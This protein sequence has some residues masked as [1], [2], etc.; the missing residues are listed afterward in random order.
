MNYQLT[1][2]ELLGEIQ[3]RFTDYNQAVKEL[4]D[5]NAQ[6]QMVNEK[7]KES[8]AMKSHF[9]SNITNEIINPFTS[10]VGLSKSILVLDAGKSA[11][12]K[13]MAD[14]IHSEAFHLDFQLK[15]IFG[16]AAIEAGDVAP[17][18]SRVNINHLID[19][20]V[21]NFQPESSKKQISIE[22]VERATAC[23][24]NQPCFVT[25]HEKLHLILSNLLSNAI[26]FSN[27][28]SHVLICAKIENKTLEFSVQ[29]FGIGI[30]FENQ[31]KIF[32]RF[33]RIDNGI[34]SLNRGHGLG[35]SI[36][37]AFIDLLDGSIELESRENKGSKFIV[38]LPTPVLEKIPNDFAEDGTELF[39]GENE[40]F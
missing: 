17:Q 4:S 16:A 40:I 15:N 22:F 38:R 27:P 19:T 10:I 24:E 3:K 25:D 21:D 14:L 5:L 34:N 9:I 11:Q 32:D 29:D 8:E 23:E 20:I 31:M 12:I 1:D 28:N 13:Q 30:A 37:K 18:F 39:F 36:N 7:L 26:K 33:V 2:E 35:L 6:L